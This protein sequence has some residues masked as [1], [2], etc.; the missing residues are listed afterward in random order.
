[1][2]NVEQGEKLSRVLLHSIRVLNFEFYINLE[3]T[4]FGEVLILTLGK[5]L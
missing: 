2:E 1:V 3:R 4:V 5:L